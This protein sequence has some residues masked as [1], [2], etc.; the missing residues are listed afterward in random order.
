MDNIRQKKTAESPITAKIAARLAAGGFA[1]GV[2]SGIFGNG[3]GVVV[4]FLFGSMAGRLFS[5]RREIFSGVT[6]AVLPMAVT[7]ALI[8][9]SYSPPSLA[10]TVA[11]AAA[12]LA[13]GTVGALLLGKIK[14]D[15]LKKI[16]AAVMIVSGVM[17]LALG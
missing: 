4:V 6:A 2:V 1:A 12:S 14:P 15:V 16:F 7:S 9:S 3:G 17:M 10:D 8:Y 11:V 5:D 13:G